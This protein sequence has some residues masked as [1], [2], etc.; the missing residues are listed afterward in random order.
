MSTTIRSF[1]FIS[2][3]SLLS[4]PSAARSLSARKAQTVA[5]KLVREWADSVRQATKQAYLDKTMTIDGAAMPLAWS[6]DSAKGASGM[7]LFISLHGGGGAP[8]QL[9]DQQWQNQ[10]RLYKTDGVYLCPRAPF[11]TW[12]LHFHPESDTFYR[13]IIAMMVAWLDVD[14]NR[15]YLMGYSAGGDG[16]WRLAPRMADAWAAA[17][18]MAGHPG[19]VRLDNLYNL[20]FM[21]WCGA[22]DAAY[23]RN[24]QCRQRIA[25]MDSLHRAHPDGYRFEGHIVEGKGHWMDRVDTAAVGWMSRFERDPFPA[26]I[27][28]RQADVL[29]Q[30]F[31][32]V[33]APENELARDKEVRLRRQGNTIDIERADYS[34]VTLW[35]SDR[36]FNLD[37]PLT[38]RYRGRTIFHGKARRSGAVMRQTLFLRD[39]PSYMCPALLTLTL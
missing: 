26:V 19:D 1:L 23:D 28:W 9:N 15:V 8:A 31:Y 38:V 33:S 6:V 21:I 2:L 20:P 22:E 29:K 37:K 39:D 32:W 12:D 17:S 14:P 10:Q 36:V 24:E 34:Q 18:M 5:Q 4:L 35:L 7:P 25:Q 11:N 30:Y 3:F 16:V 13:R 27:V